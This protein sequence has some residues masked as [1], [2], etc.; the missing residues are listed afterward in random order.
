MN[1]SLMEAIASDSL[2]LF[3]EQEE[4]RGVQTINGAEFDSTISK[5]I[6]TPLSDDQTSNSLHGDGLH[7]K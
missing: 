2:D 4:A 7:E 5:V 1:M 6:K 3:I